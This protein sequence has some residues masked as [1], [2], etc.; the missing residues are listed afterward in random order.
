VFVIHTVIAANTIRGKQN[1]Y[2]CLNLIYIK[3]V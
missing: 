1:T 3:K 2:K